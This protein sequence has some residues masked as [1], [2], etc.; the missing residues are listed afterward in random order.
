MKNYKEEVKA[1]RKEWIRSKI[2][3]IED[4]VRYLKPWDYVICKDNIPRIGR[5]LEAFLS[6][7]DIEVPE[8]IKHFRNKGFIVEQNGD[9]S[10][11]YLKDNAANVDDLYQDVI[12]NLTR[13]AYQEWPSNWPK[14]ANDVLIQYGVKAY[15]TPEDLHLLREFVENGIFD[16]IL[17]KIQAMTELHTFVTERKAKLCIVSLRTDADKEIEDFFLKQGFDLISS[18][19]T[20]KTLIIPLENKQ[21]D[22]IVKYCYEEIYGNI[23][24]SLLDTMKRIPNRNAPYLYIRFNGWLPEDVKNML[25][26]DGFVIKQEPDNALRISLL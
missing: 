26:A 7:G 6:I 21:H 19:E 11:I 9:N 16:S 24:T 14:L 5:K 15:N 3:M 18:R 4:S 8:I 10:I 2:E 1:I 25:K 20:L 12:N 17:G 23:A 22:G 13:Y